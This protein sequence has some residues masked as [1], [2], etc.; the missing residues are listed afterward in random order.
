MSAGPDRPRLHLTPSGGWLNDPHGLT[1]HEGAYHLFFQAVPDGDAWRTG[2]SWGHATSLDLLSWEHLPAALE[3]GEGDL[4]CWS[5]CL[6]T[7]PTGAPRIF[8]TSVADPDHDLGVIREAVAL[9]AGLRRWRKGRWVVD[10]AGAVPPGSRGLRVFRDPQVVP[11]GAGW[12]MLVGAGRGDGRPGVLGYS[13]ADLRSWEPEGDV[14]VG[15]APPDWAGRAWECPNL[16]EAD[17][18]HVLF[19]SVWDDGTDRMA[20]A[21][22]SAAEGR[23]V[24]DR[25]VTVASGPRGP[26]A[27]SVFRDALGRPCVIF[28]LRGIADEDAGWAGALSVPYVVRVIDGDLAL[29][30][31]PA[32]VEAVA[33][34]AGPAS[35]AGNDVGAGAG[36]AS[37][38]WSPRGPADTVRLVDGAGTILA[39]AMRD[40]NEVVL[41]SDRDE[42]R[43]PVGVRVWL[44]ADGPVLEACS[45]SALASLRVPVGRHGCSWR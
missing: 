4:G 15:T 3:P 33:C 36:P 9:D 38:T 26:Y 44:L 17:G 16:V 39:V 11:D 29:E 12:R 19:V 23:F 22:G 31:H 43:L 21:V 42:A 18:A 32:V 25:W 10:A 14:V 13:S 5:G 41:R 35:A 27:G 6:V 24:A 40:G 34:S 1:W 20:A 8:Y 7:P 30:P 2:V 45:G 28:W 37:L